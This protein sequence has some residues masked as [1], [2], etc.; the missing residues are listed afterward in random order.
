M[1][2]KEEKIKSAK[3][4]AT[5]LAFGSLIG[6]AAGVMLAPKSGKDLRKDISDKSIEGIDK[7]K[8][9]T[10]KKLDEA[11]ELAEKA[12]PKKQEQIMVEVGRKRLENPERL[13]SIDK[14]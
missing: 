7:A 4:V 10:V 8:E 12:K 5:G 6:A 14:I 2:K 9:I 13:E 3:S 11:K 1:N